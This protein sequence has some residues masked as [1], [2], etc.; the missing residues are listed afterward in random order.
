MLRLRTTSQ[1]QY[2]KLELQQLKLDTTSEPTQTAILTAA[3]LSRERERKTHRQTDRQTDGRTDRRTD[4]RTDGRTEGQADRLGGLIQT[5]MPS[6][7]PH[8]YA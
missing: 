5:N 6:S 2:L 4:G 8:R 7:A 1:H 3:S